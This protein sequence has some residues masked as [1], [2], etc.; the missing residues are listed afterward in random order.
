MEDGGF[1]QGFSLKNRVGGDREEEHYIA[2]I[3]PSPIE[4]SWYFPLTGMM[5]RD[6]FINWLR[7]IFY[8]AL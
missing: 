8:W 6:V 1:D 2:K 7:T 5:K 4:R 3:M